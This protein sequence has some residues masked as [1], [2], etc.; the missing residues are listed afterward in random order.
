MDIPMPHQLREF[1]IAKTPQWGGK[2]AVEPH[3]GTE[4]YGLRV[5]ADKAV[6][7][8]GTKLVSYPVRIFKIGGEL[9]QDE[10]Q[11]TRAYREYVVNLP[12]AKG[13]PS[14]FNAYPD[15]RAILSHDGRPL[16]PLGMF[17][18]EPGLADTDGEGGN[19]YMAYFSGRRS[20]RGRGELIL[21]AK[22]RIQ[23]QEWLTWCYG[24]DFDRTTYAM[25]PR[26]REFRPAKRRRTRTAAE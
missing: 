15:V 4:I 20:H 19:A 16:A 14:A 9:T 11:L 8:D 17:A 26:C 23:P 1:V 24:P 2:Y 6:G 12:T 13:N 5:V 7:G 10:M 25:M 3:P 18:N 21:K 22:R